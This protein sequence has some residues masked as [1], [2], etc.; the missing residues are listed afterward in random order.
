MANT[1]NIKAVITAEDR[2][3]ATLKNFGDGVSNVAHKA[4]VALEV[5][6]VAM[7][8]FGALSVKAFM[9]SEN[10][11]AQTNA[12]LKSTGGVAGVTEKAV[13]DLAKSLQKVT[14]YSDEEVRSA[15]NLLLTFTNI[16][17][18]VFPDATEAALDMS[19]ALN[20]DLK[21]STI[22][23]GKALQDPIGGLTA[24]KK[25]GV[26]VTEQFKTY[27]KTIVETQ[28]V[29]AGQV[30]ILKELQTEF[31]GSA[32]AAGK[33]FSG[34]LKILKNQVNDVQESLGQAI[35]KGLV[36]FATKAT[37]AIASVDWEKVIDKTTKKLGELWKNYLVP[38]GDAVK[39]AGQKI[40]QYLKPK[41]EALWN[42]IKQALP[43]FKQLYE[44]ILK[45][46]GKFFGEVFVLAIGLAIDALNLFLQ[47]ITPVIQWMIDHKQLVIDFAG[48][49]T[50]LAIAL[51]FNDV[52]DAFL[53]N[54]SQI[55][56]SITSVKN[57][58]VALF[59]KIGG[60]AVMGGIVTAGAL[61]DI[62]LVMQA[63]QSVLG[64]INAM[65]KA[66]EAAS[67]AGASQNQAI[68]QVQDA[69]KAGKISKEQ[70]AKIIASFGTP[71]ITKRASGGT[72]NA[73][74]T[75]MVGEKGP[76]L[77]TAKQGGNIVPNDKLGGANI[78]V[79]FS[80]IFTGNKQ[81]F[82]KLAI[83]VF[84]AHDDAKRMGA[85]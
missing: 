69:I 43:T 78:N 70:G 45:P 15:E 50:A 68:K 2:A 4:K 16:G 65:N 29:E 5:A 57:E 53:L 66:S 46:L 38:F 24:L 6:G 23:I 76:E 22:R 42:T 67:S 7:V 25:A 19:T 60:G 40:A 58:V 75:Y 41:L 81:E 52:K 12:V 49:F 84:R 26:N 72:V 18:K 14:K 28:G 30:A 11:I 85:Y 36:P 21:S 37:T 59:T 44:E 31:G 74:Q 51:K 35:V 33:T 82:R 8:A 79:T 71:G 32:K 34:Q 39:D 17:K 63:V 48:A 13:N 77:F 54:M 20:E 9:E 83:E 1:A 3:S 10:A 47:I 64:A 55:M 62:A 56:G 73:G 61:A 27:I 80:G